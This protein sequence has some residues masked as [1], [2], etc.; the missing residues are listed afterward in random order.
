MIDP[1]VRFTDAMAKAAQSAPFDP[2]AVSLATSTP[3]GRPSCRIVLLH[4]VDARGFVFHTNY[5][6]RKGQQIEGNPHAALC[7]YWPWTE[8]QIRVEGT[9]ARVPSAESDAYFASRPRGSQ[10]GAW[11]S[12]QSEPV[13]SREALL[14]R[15]K[16]FE[17]R[18]AGRDVPRPEHWGGYRLRPLRIEF[19]K[20]GE[21][22]LHDRDLY[23]RVGE[24]WTMQRLYP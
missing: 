9:V 12:L 18:F 5:A 21:F 20:A 13:E 4:E 8:E 24:A 15:V 11:A 19:W 14:A 16:D 23:E 17:A 6:G 3:D 2:I 10:V 22:R 7:A 1:I